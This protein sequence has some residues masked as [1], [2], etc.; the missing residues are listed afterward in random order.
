MPPNKLKLKREGVIILLI[1]LDSTNSHGN[2]TR[3]IVE[4]LHNNMIDATVASGPYAGRRLFI[5]QIP[6]VPSEH[7]FPFQMKRKQFPIRPAF[8]MAANKS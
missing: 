5:N 4:N 2:D 7:L 6:L 8:A 3:N 1:N